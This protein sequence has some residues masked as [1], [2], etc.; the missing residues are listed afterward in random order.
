MKRFK[1]ILYVADFNVDQTEAIKRVLALA[2]SNQADL[3]V[4]LVEE[5]PRLGI[6]DEL[7][8]RDEIDQR[9]HQQQL[10]K[11]NVLFAPYGDYHVL[12]V[13]VRFGKPFIEIIRTVLADHHD[14]VIKAATSGGVG[15]RF[16]VSQDMHLLR[17]C[18]CPVWLMRANEKPNYSKILAALDFDPWHPNPEDE[19]LNGQIMELGSAVALADFAE[20]N[21]VHVWDSMLTGWAGEISKESL[22]L[23]V[24]KERSRY[25]RGLEMLT[26]QLRRLLG[27][28]AYNYL[29]PKLHLVRGDPREAIPT[30]VASLG[31]DLVVMGTLA[32]T[33]ISGLFIGNTA[34]LILNRIDCSVLAIKPDHFVSP[35]L[36]E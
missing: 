8:S 22:D 18:P 29:S 17:E 14:L 20:L 19:Q 32:R 28:Q 36:V 24:N 9:L 3:A 15:D 31:V 11:L 25:Q 33:G 34:E 35:V 4:L 26:G 12:P 10:D 23:H 21:F 5:T 7:F 27:N 2:D 30:L 16:F 6:L 13:Q 1:N